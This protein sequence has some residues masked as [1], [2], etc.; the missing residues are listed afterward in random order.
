MRKLLCGL[1]TAAVVGAA[2]AYVVYK[3]RQN[4]NA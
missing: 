4:K 1:V 3:Y 2:V